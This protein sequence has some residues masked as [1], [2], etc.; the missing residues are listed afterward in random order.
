M[1]NIDGEGHTVTVPV[2]FEIQ[3][4]LEKR[5]PCWSHLSNNDSINNSISSIL[6]ELKVQ[7][8]EDE[9]KSMKNWHFNFGAAE[10]CCAFSSGR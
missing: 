1:P 9:Q 8:V 2:L 10:T 6:G 3:Q 5:H 7:F 4:T